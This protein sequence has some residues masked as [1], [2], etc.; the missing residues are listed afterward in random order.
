MNSLPFELLSCIS[1]YT[2]T[3]FPTDI[4]IIRSNY[5]QL[6]YFALKN[7]KPGFL[8]ILLDCKQQIIP[9]AVQSAA[10]NGYPECLQLLLAAGYS[11]DNNALWLAVKNKHKEC[12]D[13]LLAAGLKPHKDLGYW[14]TGYNGNC[15]CLR[16]LLEIGCPIDEYTISNVSHYNHIASLELLLDAK[17][18]MDVNA[19]FEATKMGNFEC[20]ELLLGAGCPVRPD[21]ISFTV[22]HCYVEKYGYGDEHHDYKYRHEKCFELLRKSFL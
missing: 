20:L 3:V 4:D 8:R 12:V 1:Q 16:S 6:F 11:M 22:D 5:E 19:T 7:N 18:P 13:V 15:E 10:G 21:A 2:Q 9:D 14:A 17:C